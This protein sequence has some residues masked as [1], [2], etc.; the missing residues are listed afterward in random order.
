MKFFQKH[1]RIALALQIIFYIG[2]IFYI[3]LLCGRAAERN[4]YNPSTFF[5]WLTHA[6]HFPNAASAAACTYLV[7]GILA[8]TFILI[9]LQS[10]MAA[11]HDCRKDFQ[12]IFNNLDH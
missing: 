9:I 8:L 10:I 7:G 12:N 1:H 11:I 3:G 2:G 4:F 5:V 6:L